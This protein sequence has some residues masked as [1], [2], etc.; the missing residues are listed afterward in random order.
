MTVPTHD[1]ISLRGAGI[2]D[3]AQPQKGFRFN[4]DSLLLADFCSIKPRDRVLELG[5]GT[6]VVSLLLAKKFPQTR[7]TAV[8]VEPLAYDLL[9]RNIALNGIVDRIVPLDRDIQYLTRGIAPHAFDVI[10]AN[11]PYTPCGTGKKNSTPERQIARHDQAG[12]LGMWLD[13]QDLL[14]NKGRYFLVFPAVRMAELVTLLRARKLEPKRL[15][16]VHPYEN[17]PASL[18]LIEALKSGQTGL[19]IQPPLI[20]HEPGGGYTEEMREIYGIP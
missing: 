15:R 12:T 1:S 13:C 18:V 9:C 14:K 20:V 17:K 4:L 19:E 16:V 8:E 7:V 10:V 11:P 5:A 3:I 2:V 6:G